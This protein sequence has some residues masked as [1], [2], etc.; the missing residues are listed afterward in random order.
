MKTIELFM[1]VM[2][3][4][5]A[6]QVIANLMRQTKQID[7]LIIVDNCDQFYGYDYIFEQAKF[8]VLIHH[9]GKNIGTNAVW[10]KM[11]Q[12]EADYVGV[13]CDDI[14]IE[15]VVIQG[16]YE[17]F[18]MNKRIGAT[19]ATVFK[20]SKIRWRYGRQLPNWSYRE[21]RGV[22]HFGVALIDRTVLQQIPRIPEQ[23]F[24]FFGDNWL[25]Y[26]LKN[27]GRPLHEVNVGI[28]HNHSTDLKEKLDY[29]SMLKKER[30]FWIDWKRANGIV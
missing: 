11:W 22:G 25:G 13:L 17:S 19:S 29:P 16:L 5:K 2:R 20:D 27:V 4:D 21:T 6:L 3:V 7:S 14:Y 18:D 23:L 30:K 12:S 15:D 1:P 26:H 10:N 8:K 9:P 24:V 28:R